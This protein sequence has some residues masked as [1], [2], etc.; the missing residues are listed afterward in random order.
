[1]KALMV[2]EE[3]TLRYE[4]GTLCYF[5][6]EPPIYDFERT[7]MLS[8]DLR[9]MD[10]VRFEIYRQLRRALDR[11]WALYPPERGE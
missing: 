3:G 11:T 2:D 5:R 8:G 1:M 9:S 4:D 10:L 7:L 6:V